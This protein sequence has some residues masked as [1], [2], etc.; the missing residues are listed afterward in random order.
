MNYCKGCDDKQLRIEQL[1]GMLLRM[2]ESGR[3]LLVASGRLSEKMGQVIEFPSPAK[4]FDRRR[5]GGADIFTNSYT[6]NTK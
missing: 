1:E 4:G 3:E 5:E 6:N 2:S